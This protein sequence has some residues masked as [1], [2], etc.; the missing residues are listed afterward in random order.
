ML[1]MQIGSVILKYN[2]NKENNNIMDQLIQQFNNIETNFSIIYIK[3][4]QIK[5]STRKWSD[6]YI[7]IVFYTKVLFSLKKEVL[8]LK[9]WDGIGQKKMKKFY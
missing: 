8:L 9:I 1:L 7:T 2:I 3:P 6:V 5:N 4:N